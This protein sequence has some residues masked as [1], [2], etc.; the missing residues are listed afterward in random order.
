MFPQE[1]FHTHE[2]LTHGGHSSKPLAFAVNAGKALQA[3]PLPRGVLIK[4][5]Q[6]R[7]LGGWRDRGVS[8][9][10]HHPLIFHILNISCVLFLVPKSPLFAVP[11]TEELLKT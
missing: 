8:P 1:W 2:E 10:S 9:A 5:R 7:I 6:S 3:D 4:L 11:S